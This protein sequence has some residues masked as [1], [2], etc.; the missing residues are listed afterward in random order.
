MYI[1]ECLP[2]M[3]S[4][5]RESL[6]YF[7]SIKIEVGSLVKVEIRKQKVFAL[8]LGCLEANNKK[9]DIKSA[10]FQFK[11]IISINSKPFLSKSFLEGIKETADFFATSSGA[12]LSCIFPSIIF[13]KND[14]LVYQKETRVKNAHKF[15]FDAIQSE[16]G[17][18]FSYYKTVIRENFAQK[19]S[20]YVCLPQNQNIKFLEP[21]LSKGIEQHSYVFHN[22]LTEKEMIA[23]WKSVLLSKHPVL[24]IATINFFG[25]PR[26]DIGTIIVE[27]ENDNGWKSVSRPFLDYKILIEIV[28]RNKNLRL[29]IGDLALSTETIFKYK[30]FRFGNENLKWR[31]SSNV[32]NVLIELNNKKNK[33]ENKKWQ[34][35]SQECLNEIKDTLEKKGNVFVYSSRK[36]LASFTLCQDCGNLVNCNNC[37]ATMILHGRNNNIFVCHQCGETRSAEE[38]C[39]VCGS[40]RL[41]AFGMGIEKITAEI[42][43]H[44]P[45][46]EN[47]NKIFELDSDLANT[48]TKAVRIVDNFL[49]QDGSILVGTHMALNYLSRKI[50]TTV[51][52]SLD[53]LFAIPNFKIREKIFNLILSIK[54]LANKKFVIQTRNFGEALI[55]Y[56]LM[57]NLS[58]FY[59]SE[60]K[61]REGLDYPPFSVFVKITTLG[62]KNFVEKE[63][64]KI[65]PLFQKWQPVTFNSIHEKKGN[66]NAVNT[67]IKIKKEKW[68]D[69]KLISLLRSLPPHFEIKIDPDNLL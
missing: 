3:K 45:Y 12:V 49:S 43:K 42:K 41:T 59:R 52:L 63:T 57:G 5:N 7:S 13:K 22:G 26:G 25:I 51:I 40:W 48:G 2:L 68:P 21:I 32:S 15:D 35:V 31:L 58:D 20:V 44:F 34:I 9:M 10:D 4:F 6:S 33:E 69:E 11:K 17:E 30:Q 53:S 61:E 8:V 37:G 27:N 1:I 28:A 64:K 14:L 50:D 66:Q 55:N 67:V 62:S 60:L 39:K 36:G 19:K 16:D 54:N 24:I 18:R 38:V 65:E 29:I 23:L 47:E 46:L 56:A